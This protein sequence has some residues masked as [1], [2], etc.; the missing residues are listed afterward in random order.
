MKKIS[1]LIMVLLVSF[2]LF[3]T[4]VTLKTSVDS[5]QEIK[6]L[7]GNEEVSGDKNEKTVNLQ[8]PDA[9][10]FRIVWSGNTA[11]N[12]SGFTIG[13]VAYGF[14]HESVPRDSE[15]YHSHVE[16][17]VTFEGLPS[18]TE[19]DSLTYTS[20]GITIGKGDKAAEGSMAIINF[21]P[22]SHL[23]GEYTIA[24]FT[25][26]WEGAQYNWTAGSYACDIVFTINGV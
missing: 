7:Y 23:I 16:V 3:A 18:S 1:A 17:P 15:D 8:A 26:T 25:P 10:P 5:H 19:P 24:E 20:G 9:Q 4:D 12:P 21:T 13:V 14:I 11:D 6:I 22:S 2:T